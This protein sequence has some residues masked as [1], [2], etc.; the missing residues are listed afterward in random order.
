MTA[1]VMRTLVQSTFM[2]F[3]N[4]IFGSDFHVSGEWKDDSGMRLFQPGP[5]QVI[6]RS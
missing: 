6:D 4:V 2:G 5:G 3:F 1:Q